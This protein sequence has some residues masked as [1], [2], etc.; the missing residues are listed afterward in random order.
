MHIKRI[1]GCKY[2][3]LNRQGCVQSTCCGISLELKSKLQSLNILTDD[4][5]GHDLY[6]SINHA[7][8]SKVRAGRRRW[9]KRGRR[10]DKHGRIHTLIT[11]DDRVHQHE[12]DVTH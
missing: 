6:Y 11:F 12:N 2:I 9:R 3:V 4:C 5:H 8:F 10:G 7:I 1:F